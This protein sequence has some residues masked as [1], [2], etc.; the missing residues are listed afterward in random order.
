MR[1]KILSLLVLLM[2][3]ASGA[4]AQKQITIT[5][6]FEDGMGDWTMNHC[7]SGTG[8][9]SAIA[10]E[11][12]NC[13]RFY[14]TL[15]YPQYLIS[16]ELDENDGGTMSFYYARESS[17][18]IESFKVGYSTT[19]SDPS[20]FTWGNQQTVSNG[21][22]G[23]FFNY[24][25]NF[26]AGTKYV[27]IA[28]TSPDQFYLFIDDI[29]IEYV[30]PA[31]PNAVEV[32]T[33]AAS[34]GATFTEASFKM[35][36]FDATV[37]YDIVRDMA[38]Q[39]T[40]TVGGVTDN[41][42]YRIRLKKD[43]SKWKLADLTVDQVMAQFKVHDAIE[44]TDLVFSG[45]GAVCAISIYAL[46]DQ[47]QPTGNAI[48]FANLEPGRYVAIA[49]AVDGSAYDGQTAQSNAIV[50][51]QGYEV[52]IPAGEMITYYKD[53][54][55][56]LE[57]NSGAQLYTITAVADGKATATEL[58]I[59]PANT[60]ILVKNLSDTETK[61]FLLIPTEETAD[62]VTA[63]A[64]F[65]GTLT[66]GQIDASTSTQTNYAFNGKQFVYVKTAIPVAA[67][68]AWLEVP[69]STSNAR[70]VTL[71]F[72][73]TT[74]IDGANISDALDGDYYDLN[75]RKLQGLPTK[76]GIYIKNGR[77]VVVK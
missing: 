29:K 48:S 71:V 30:A 11:G 41:S 56:K 66:A 13:F 32:T 38:V 65:T 18:Y 14:Y 16:P 26:P 75:G 31:D 12:S 72:D 3:A 10:Y 36:A 40:T 49:K 69:V 57:E 23:D 37:N 15:N 25:Y 58:T 45:D 22:G 68:K 35:P 52:T 54:N 9:N 43:G 53:E 60:A 62:N 44:N 64:G 55:L 76:K 51:F 21:D 1:N 20:A 28:C 74:R 27:S 5:Q 77:K 6:G 46:D 34:E 50:L 4:W 8:I 42:D 17:N 2:T 61:T 67:N 70:T 19:T 24:T 47:D 7:Q 39:M 73:N 59:S 63:Y 33:N